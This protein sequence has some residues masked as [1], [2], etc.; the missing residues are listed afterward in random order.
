LVST[1]VAFAIGAGLHDLCPER[2]RPP[3]VRYLLHPSD[4]ELEEY[5]NVWW[6]VFALERGMGLLCQQPISVPDD[7]IRT[8]WPQSDEEY[9]RGEIAYGGNTVLLLYNNRSSASSARGNSAVALLAKSFALYE[10]ATRIGPG[11]VDAEF[12]ATD[13]A[14]KR[15]YSSLPQIYNTSGPV[16]T[17]NPKVAFA[18]TFALGALLQ[19][20]GR[21][22]QKGD[23]ESYRT[24]LEAVNDTIDIILEL[25]RYQVDN[26]S[27]L[28]GVTWLLAR[29]FLERELTKLERAAILDQIKIERVRLQLGEVKWAFQKVHEQLSR[30]TNNQ[31]FTRSHPRPR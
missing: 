2:Y 22:A 16:D 14:I 13:N 10:R 28:M 24:C 31:D 4:S 30:Y 7:K 15:F 27:R 21:L 23:H 11:A 9:E 12:K 1:T 18:R 17:I 26:I 29:E 5:I 19:L 6:Q 25:K 20:Y 3:G 8:P